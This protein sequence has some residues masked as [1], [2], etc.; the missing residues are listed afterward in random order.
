MSTDNQNLVITAVVAAVG[1]YGVSVAY[2]GLNNLLFNSD[3]KSRFAPEF[4]RSVE[5]L[6]VGVIGLS[7]AVALL[8]AADNLRVVE[9]RS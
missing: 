3:D 2:T 6:G 7:S 5:A 8:Y 1:A 4:R 9:F